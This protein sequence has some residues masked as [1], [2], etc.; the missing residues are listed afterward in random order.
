[1]ASNVTIH[2]AGNGAPVTI[3]ATSAQNLAVVQAVANNIL[4]LV[5]HNTKIDGLFDS[6]SVPTVPGGDIG[7]G[8][9]STG[10]SVTLPDAKAA[11]KTA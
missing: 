3:S 11:A 4:T 7:V 1:M 5:G 9:L 10:A 8:Y 2:G 6:G